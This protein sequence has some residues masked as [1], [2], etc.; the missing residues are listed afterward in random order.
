[1]NEILSWAAALHTLPAVMLVLAVVGAVAC[2]VGA[3]FDDLP[4]L[5]DS[6]A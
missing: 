5:G 1:M 2:L 4:P 3:F 6:A